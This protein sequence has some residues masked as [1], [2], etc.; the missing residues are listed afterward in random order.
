IDGR[1]RLVR[2]DRLHEMRMAANL[3][4]VDAD[5]REAEIGTVL[6]LVAEEGGHAMW[7]RHEAA[8]RL[9]PSNDP[10]GRHGKLPQL[11]HHVGDPRTGR[12]DHPSGAIAA[13]I[14]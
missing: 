11:R 8:A 4:A 6:P 9:I 2:I 14:R 7:L 5:G 12:D 10:A 3:D 13:Y 1:V